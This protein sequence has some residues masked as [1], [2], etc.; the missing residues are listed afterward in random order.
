MG[1]EVYNYN[2]IL[3]GKSIFSS[4]TRWAFRNNFDHILFSEDGSNINNFKIKYLNK[5]INTS[6]FINGVKKSV[7]RTNHFKCIKEKYSSKI[8][9]LFVSRLL[10]LDKIRLFLI[11]FDH[12]EGQ[13]RIQH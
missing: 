4:I 11:G 5:K 13:V 7:S 8:K 9:L 1:V 2:N 3:K 12:F 10:R 6:T